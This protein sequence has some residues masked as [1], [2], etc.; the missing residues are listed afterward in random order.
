MKNTTTDIGNRAS[1][2]PPPF[3]LMGDLKA[4]WREWRQ[5]L[6]ERVEEKLERERAFP[7]PRRRSR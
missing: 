5:V 6:R 1:Y 2:G 4:L 3:N 7:K